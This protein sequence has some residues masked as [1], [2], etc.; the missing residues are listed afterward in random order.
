MKI[1]NFDYDYMISFEDWEICQETKLL[2]EDFLKHLE[3]FKIVEKEPIK[4][5]NQNKSGGKKKNYKNQNNEKKT[6]TDLSTFGR[7]DISKEIALAE[8]FKKKIDEEASKDP[9]RFQITEHLNIL[10]VDNYKQTS[11]NIYEIIKDDIENQE[12]F[13]DVLFN[14]SVNEK[15]YVKLYAKLCKDFDKKLPQKSQK[16]RWKKSKKKTNFND[17]S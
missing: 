6:E 7:K 1:Y 12:K 16:K 9:I 13:L 4:I 5:S 17:E 15:A 8:E 14:K 2:S 10:T 11:E 3:N